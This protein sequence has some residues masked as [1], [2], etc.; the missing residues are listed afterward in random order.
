MSQRYTDFVK[1]IK[2]KIVAIVWIY[3]KILMQIVMI[4]SGDGRTSPFVFGSADR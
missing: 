3:I 4:G 2:T 1:R